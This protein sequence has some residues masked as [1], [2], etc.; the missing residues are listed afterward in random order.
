MIYFDGH[1]SFIDPNLGKKLNV[2]ALI[3]RF[4]SLGKYHITRY[5]R[6]TA[7]SLPL[8]PDTSLWNFEQQKNVI[9][10]N[11]RRIL[12]T[13]FSPEILE[14]DTLFTFHHKKCKL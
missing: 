13:C 3:N 8:N 4:I 6:I 7:Q 12:I 11:G 9:S 5:H 1:I 2:S 10:Q 14:T